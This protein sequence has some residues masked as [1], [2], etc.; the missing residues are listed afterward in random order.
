VHEVAAEAGRTARTARTDAD[1]GGGVGV[2]VGVGEADTAAEDIQEF[3]VD[4]AR[5]APEEHP[6]GRPGRP[7][8]RS[9]PF[10]I[11]FVGALGVLTA[12]YLVRVVV[13]ASQ[14]IV[15]VVV[16]L[17]LAVGLNP[18]VERLTRRGLSRPLSVFVVTLV[19]LAGLIGFVAAIAQPLAA[20]TTDLIDSLPDVIDELRRNRQVE[21]LNEQYGILDRAAGVLGSSALATSVFGGVLG[22]GK[23][24]LGGL[25]SLFTVLIL[26]LYFLSSLPHIKRHAYLLVP[27]TRRE[28]VSLLNDEILVRIGGYV[29]GALTIASIAGISTFVFLEII[30]L[31]YAL[32]LTLV[33]AVTAL[34]PMVGATIGAVVV[35]LVALIESPYKALACMVFFIVY[36]QVENY[37]IYPRVMKRWVDVPPAMT[38]IAALVGGTM[39]GVIGA[40]MAIPIAAAVLLV[41]REVLVPRQDRV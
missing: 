41:V 39:L 13:G 25:F 12:W 38:V 17:L 30:Q 4:E 29:H 21:R 35:S 8:R 37:V 10:Y 6:F 19:L 11:G 9:S 33:V 18:T 1:V 2:G 14:V 5:P 20:Q 27:R 34:V 24:V 15:L 23:F 40:L 7:L 26:T 31:P 3:L 36:Q 22:I 32:P 28:R 16:S